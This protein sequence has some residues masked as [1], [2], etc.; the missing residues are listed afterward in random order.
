[1][2][3]GIIMQSSYV[4]RP[5]LIDKCPRESKSS[6]IWYGTS[7]TSAGYPFN[8]TSI[9][10][11]NWVSCLLASLILSSWVSVA[12]LV[13]STK[14][15][16]AWTSSAV[17]GSCSDIR[18]LLD[19]VSATTISLRSTKYPSPREKEAMSQLFGV[20]KNK[21]EVCVWPC[22]LLS[23]KS[24][25]A[26]LS[27][28]VPSLKCSGWVLNLFVL[29]AI[30]VSNCNKQNG[31]KKFP[32]FKIENFIDSKSKVVNFTGILSVWTFR[33]VWLRF[34]RLANQSSAFIFNTTQF[35]VIQKYD[36][37]ICYQVFDEI[38]QIFLAA[39]RCSTVN[40][41]FAPFFFLFFSCNCI[42]SRIDRLA[43]RPK[44]IRRFRFINV[45]SYYRRLGLW[46][47]IWKEERPNSK[48][49]VSDVVE[50]TAK[51]LMLSNKKD[52]DN[53]ERR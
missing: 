33:F 17:W 34:C 21:I 51:M 49:I 31:L 35:F 50:I 41:W 20:P 11:C 45:P 53:C 36:L 39:N 19:W 24:N 23:T 27:Q 14:S 30:A 10:F 26:L 37:S 18:G 25:F 46:F 47:G 28:D 29:G 16:N 40:E 5:L 15:T 22:F 48:I 44:R 38:K 52:G 7:S 6:R 42:R 32:R 4:R 9:T 3:A 1:M 13:D 43:I 2:P 12:G 8:V